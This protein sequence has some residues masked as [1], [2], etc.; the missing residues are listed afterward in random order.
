[1]TNELVVF[2]DS[3]EDFNDQRL[4]T[5]NAEPLESP[6]ET[7][8]GEHNVDRFHRDPRTWESAAEDILGRT[9]KI[10]A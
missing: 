6:D 9:S 3:L 8:L 10:S 7:A 4:V 2:A 1:M 5:G